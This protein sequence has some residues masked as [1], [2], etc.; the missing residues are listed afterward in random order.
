MIDLSDNNISS[1][2]SMGEKSPILL[3]SLA[4]PDSPVNPWCRARRDSTIVPHIRS[5]S[6]LTGRIEVRA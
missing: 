3:R 6:R 1:S 4:V 2:I 5:L